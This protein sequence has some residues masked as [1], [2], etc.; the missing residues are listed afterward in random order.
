MGNE[1]SGIASNALLQLSDA[2]GNSVTK[3]M[4]NLS[5]NSE[6]DTEKIT[7][8]ASDF[9]SILLASWLQSAEKSFAT[10]PGG[11]PENENSDPGRGQFQDF[12]VQAVAKALTKAG[13]IGIAGMIASSLEKSSGAAKGDSSPTLQGT[14]PAKGPIIKN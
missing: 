11:D 6:T 2:N 5:S 9:E 1:I 3:K 13:G 8:S 7:R 14:A 12:G 10:V 4:A